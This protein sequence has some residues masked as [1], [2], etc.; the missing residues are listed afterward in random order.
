MIIKVTYV[1]V[2]MFTGVTMKHDFPPKLHFLPVT[3]V[4]YVKIKFNLSVHSKN[5]LFTFI[6]YK[7]LIQIP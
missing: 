3:P 7:F 4:N 5:P 1:A 2:V 6:F